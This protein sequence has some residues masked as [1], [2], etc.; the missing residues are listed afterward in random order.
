[1][2]KIAIDNYDIGNFNINPKYWFSTIT[3]K[4]NIMKEIEDYLLLDLIQKVESHKKNSIQ[5]FIIESVIFLIVT[6]LTLTLGLI[7]V[8]G[9]TKSVQEVS[10]ESHYLSSGDLTVVLDTSNNDELGKMNEK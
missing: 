1:M 3:E 7:V 2:R 5:V 8:P 10:D 4:I 6:I 9:I